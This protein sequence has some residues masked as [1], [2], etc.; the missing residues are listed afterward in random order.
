AVI[1]YQFPY[2]S[3]NYGFLLHDADTGQTA[4]IDAGCAES[5]QLA[6]D[7]TGFTLT[8]IWITHHHWDHTDGLADLKAATGAKIVGPANTKEAIATYCDQMISDGEGFIFAGQPVKIIATPGHTLD[9]MNY[10]L[11]DEQIIFTGDTL[12]TL[13]C[14]RLFEGDGPMMWHSLSKLRALPAKTMIYSA[15]EYSLAN[16]AFA[17]SV[18]PDNQALKNRA[19]DI[20]ASRDKGQP[21][22]PSCLADECATNPFLRPDD[23]AIR[24]HLD[25]EDAS[26]EAVF[27][28]IRALKDAF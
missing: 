19:A 27:T 7:K 24:R 11:P 18:D 4:A 21:T 3:D 23:T 5:Y 22:V 14:G 2:H 8:E 1:C 13:G 15:H 9:M 26:D 20:Q 28:K 16:A 25:M 12:F 10:Y 17:L 6:L